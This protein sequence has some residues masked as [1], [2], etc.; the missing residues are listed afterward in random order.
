MF[1][2]LVDYERIIILLLYPSFTGNTIMFI[3]FFIWLFIALA[4]SASAQ[5]NLIDFVKDKTL[6]QGFFFVLS[7]P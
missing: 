2:K 7:R 3:R 4:S 6:H 1:I 5:S